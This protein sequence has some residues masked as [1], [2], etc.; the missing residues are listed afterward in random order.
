[1][2]D[3]RDDVIKYIKTNGPVLPVQISKHINTN[4]LFS[5]AILAELVERKMLK[6]THFSI[7]GSPLYYLEG[8]E[9]FMDERLGASLSGREKE[10][11]LFIKEKKVT[12][13]SELEPWQ[14]VAIKSLKDFTSQINVV[15]AGHEETFW[16]HKV[17]NDEEAKILVQKIIDN[18]YGNF[19]NEKQIQESLD[20]P[21]NINEPL[22]EKK[23]KNDLI[24]S[25]MIVKEITEK[26]RNELLK[27]IESKKP[28]K[29][30]AKIKETLFTAETKEVQKPS[31]IFYERVIA[32]FNKSNIKIIGETT[33]KKDKEIDFLVNVPSAFGNLK[34]F[35]K[36]K[37]K[38]S[39]TEN[40]VSLA[41]SDGQIKKLPII[42]LVT[43]KVNKKAYDLAE[44]KLNGQVV[45]SHV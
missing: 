27:D 3:Q 1:M 24:D 42:M 7:G 17:V 15:A 28:K 13:E 43:G 29:E 33:I 4:I 11:Y 36:A 31:G 16:K 8:Q 19:D 30:N 2:A 39:I 32:F 23:L 41:F 14:R 6:I 45:L 38:S 37:N 34:Y 44:K 10:A 18:T 40:D 26:V 22:I 12:R 9:V 21:K 20:L 35:V 5:S 25:S